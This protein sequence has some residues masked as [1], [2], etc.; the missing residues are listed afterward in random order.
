MWGRY[1][2]F[3]KSYT[4]KCPDGTIK[5]VYK[6]IDDAFP[7]YIQGMDT[8]ISAKTDLDNNSN[9]ELNATYKSKVDGLLYSLN[10]QNQ[11]LMMTFRTVYMVFCSDPCS[12]SEYFQREISKITDE[13]GKIQKL[14]MQIDGLIQILN[15]SSNNSIQVTEIY[16]NIVNQLGTDPALSVAILEMKQAR[17]DMQTIIGG[18]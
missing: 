6:N 7:L 3:T 17:I 10:D 12:S 1:I 15:S 4:I 5:T 18:A 11:S 8:S 9:N 16:T 14:K 2:P 13:Y